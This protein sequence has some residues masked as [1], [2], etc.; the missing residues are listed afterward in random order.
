MATNRQA[1][2]KSSGTER[3]RKTLGHL[4]KRASRNHHVNPRREYDACDAETQRKLFCDLWWAFEPLLQLPAADQRLPSC[5]RIR[6]YDE[7]SHS[8]ETDSVVD[9]YGIR[10]DFQLYWVNEDPDLNNNLAYGSDY[11][12]SIGWS[13]YDLSKIPGTPGFIP[14]RSKLD[15]TPDSCLP[16]NLISSQ[17][18]LYRLITVFGMPP[19]S[20]DNEVDRYK[21][22]WTYTLYWRMGRRNGK[23][24]NGEKGKLMFADNKGSFVITFPGLRRLASRL[25]R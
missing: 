12:T 19:A 10:D 1:A 13:S 22:V 2:A 3:P 21:G 14:D 24:G 20:K 23:S 7:M 11:S 18:L 16:H 25:L 9:A 4:I 17:L 15:R 8:S 6:R 5:D